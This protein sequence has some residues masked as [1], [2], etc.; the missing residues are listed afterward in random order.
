MRGARGTERAGAMRAGQGLLALLLA[1]WAMVLPAVA[2]DLTALAR[3]L[4]EASRI[5]GDAGGITLSL[6]LSQPVPWRARLMDDPPRLVMDFRE[7]DWQGLDKVPQTGPQG[8]RAGTLRPGWSRLVALLPGPMKIASAGMAT[9]GRTQV[10]VDLAP[11]SAEDFAARAAAPESPDWALPRPADLPKAEPRHDGT[12]VVVLDPGHG[13]I[14][15]GA[16]RDGVKEADLV[17]AFARELKDLMMRDGDTVVVLTRD[18][19]AFVPLETRISVSRAA[20]ADVFLSLHAD[21][22]AEGEAVGA[23]VYTLSDA[24]SDEAGRTLAERHDRADLLAGVD[25]TEQDDMVARVL[26]DMART[27]TAPRV[28]RL[29]EALVQ[30]IRGADLRMH[31]HPH[32]EAGFSVLKSPDIPSALLELGFLSSERDLKRLQDPA[33][34]AAMAGAVRLGLRAWAKDEA[35]RAGVQ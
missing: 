29:A 23:T 19:D 35:A 12:L 5:E 34:R 28:E 6:G 4:P 26:M 15:P 7:V 30:A 13:G 2:Q 27:E 21:A 33:W 16:E 31:R 32:Q 14:D 20:G 18:E 24:A 8:L 17:L 3:L 1:I 10:T 25:L 11:T 9:E 22:I